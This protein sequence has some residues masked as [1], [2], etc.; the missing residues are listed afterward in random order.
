[1]ASKAL[2]AAFIFD[3]AACTQES[4]TVDHQVPHID[5]AQSF[6]ADHPGISNPVLW[7]DVEDLIF[8]HHE[9]GPVT[10][11][12]LIQRTATPTKHFVY[13]PQTCPSNHWN[14]GD[15]ICADCGATLNTHTD[16][17][18]RSEPA[19]DMA[20]PSQAQQSSA[21]HDALDNPNDIIDALVK[22]ERFIS[23]FEDDDAQE[24][25]ADILASLRTAIRSERRHPDFLEALKDLRAAAMGFRYDVC[26]RAQGLSL[27]EA[28]VN[29]LSAALL[30]A[31]R[32]I[33]E[34]EEWTDD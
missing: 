22:A 5:R 32:I 28:G 8:D 4:G 11:D 17:T 25:I 9:Y 15:D 34:I 2:F 16:Q 31:E 6:F 1:M 10:A 30:N 12:Y 20:Q 23:G 19:A 3:E 14:G 27:D 7:A 24:G 29:M 18:S 21:S 26:N 13:I 33:A